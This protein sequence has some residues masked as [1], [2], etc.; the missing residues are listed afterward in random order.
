MTHDRSTG[1]DT[2]RIARLRIGG[3]LHVALRALCGAT[4][5]FGLSQVFAG[6]A[7]GGDSAQT[8]AI[9]RTSSNRDGE[10]WTEN[11]NG[12]VSVAPGGR[13]EIRT[14]GAVIVEGDSGTTVR[15]NLL[16]RVQAGNTD[17]ARKR[18]MQYRVR[19]AERAGATVIEVV[20]SGEN[21]QSA[22]LTVL[23]P[24]TLKNVTIETHGGAV[25]A[26]DL[27]GIVRAETGGGPMK[28][29]RIGG[30]LSALTAGG[31]IELGT[32]LGSIQCK[33]AGG[34]IQG[35]SVGGDAEIET[36]GGDIAVDRV[37]GSVRAITAGG[38]VRIGKAGGTVSASTAGGAI[39]VGQAG[40]AVTAKNS[41]GPIQ[42]GG[43]EGVKCETAGG[44]IH[45]NKVSGSLVAWTGA[46]NVVANLASGRSTLA[47]SLTTGGGDITVYIPAGA[48][49][50]IRAENGTSGNVRTI[51][52]EFP[53]L[54]IR[55]VGRM[56]VADGKLHGGG[57]LLKLTSTGGTIYIKRSP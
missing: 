19:A 1:P 6:P 12:V 50:T 40:G 11:V 35:T 25:T 55:T 49:I 43:A 26:T 48:A 38:G 4:V 37:G 36:A 3:I 42:I 9:A 23:V 46:G 13:L 18:F 22:E 27:D 28:L 39:D 20:H 14:R 17:D 44:S 5:L 7:L 54:E 45:L 30:A 56:A 24:K 21:G 47:S 33:S 2:G 29:D 53:G 52:S 16:K 10:N 15:Y 31:E 51:V 32:V 57:P 34:S 8:Q 41:G